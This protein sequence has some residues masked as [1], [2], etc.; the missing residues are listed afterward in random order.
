MQFHFLLLVLVL[1]TRCTRDGV[2]GS[3]VISILYP[4]SQYIITPLLFSKSVSRIQPYDSPWHRCQA[5]GQTLALFAAWTCAEPSVQVSST[6]QDVKHRKGI[7]TKPCSR[8][9][10]LYVLV[11][12]MLFT[13]LSFDIPHPLPAKFD[14][15]TTSIAV[16]LPAISSTFHTPHPTI[17]RERSQVLSRR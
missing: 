3:S 4:R 8:R 5:Q 16:H 11:L 15:R 1:V 9:S 7:E 14:P 2:R 12:S 10:V 17:R 13:P 6:M